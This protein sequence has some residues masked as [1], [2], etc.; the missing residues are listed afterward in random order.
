MKRI[1]ILF[2]FLVV[3][4]SYN[5]QGDFCN[6]AATIVPTFTNCSWVAGTSNNASQTLTGCSGN[7]DDDVWYTFVANSTSM[8]I[9]VDPTTGY[10]P[11]IQVFNGAGCSGTS[12]GC[13]DVNGLN[14][15]ESITLNSLTNGNTYTFRVYHYGVGSGTSNFSVCVTGIAPATNNTACNA[16]ALP[17]VSPSCNFQ[18]YTNAGSAGSNIAAPNG[19]GGSSP[20]QGGY[21]GG[22]VWFSVVVPA[23]GELD[24]HTQSIGFGDGAMALYSGSCF[25]PTLVTCD[26]D[27]GIG[28][29]PYIYRTNLTP[30]ATMYIRVWEYGNNNNGKFGICVSTPDNDNC[31]NAQWICD[32]NGY[33]GVTSSAYTIDLPG[34]MTGTGQNGV[35]NS[36]PSAPFG[37]NYTGSSPSSPIQIDNNSWLAFTANATS[38]Q[39][40]V[41]VNS[42]QN[43]NGLQMQIFQGTN[44]TNFVAVS[45]MLETTNSQ[46][47]TA[48]GLTPGQTYY[49]MVDGFAG[50]ICSYTISATSGIQV[51]QAIPQDYY[52]CAGSSTSITA[53]VSGSTSG[54]TY[55]WSSTPSGSYPNTQT[56]NVTP[57]SNTLYLVSVSGQS[58]C[59]G[60]ST[61]ATAYITVDSNPTANITT[62]PTPA[63]INS[64][65]SVNGNPSGGSGIYI[66][67]SWTG[68]G[69][70]YLS[71]TTSSSPTFNTATA[72]SYTLNYQVTDL[73]GCIGT[74][75]TTINVQQAPSADFTIAATSI[76]SGDNPITLVPNTAGGTFTATPS[77]PNPINGNS[78]DPSIAGAGTSS[79]TYQI[80]GTGNS[81]PASTTKP[82]TVT[83]TPDA[84][85]TSPTSFCTSDAPH[86]LTANSNGGTWTGPA[87]SNGVFSPSVA[88]AGTFTINYNVNTGGCSNSTSTL[89][90][91]SSTLDPTI[92]TTGPYCSADGTVDL[93]AIDEGVWSGPGIVNATTG[94]FDPSLLGNGTYTITNSIGGSCGS[95]AT[96]Q[97]TISNGACDND[98]D[99]IL[100][101]D[102]P[103]DD[104][105]GI[106]DVVED[107]NLD[108]DND[109][110]TNPTDTDGDGIPDYFDLDS[111]DDGIV[112]VIEAGGQ[113]PDGDGIIGTGPITDVDQDGLDDSVDPSQG[114]TPLPTPDSDNDGIVD[115]L[116]LDSDND[117]IVDNIEGQT[118]A[119]YTPPTGLDS[120]GDG[121]DN[122]YDADNNG[123]PV[124]PANTDLTDLPDYLDNDSDNDGDSDS[125]EGYD[126]DNDGTANITPSGNDSDSD[127]IDDAYDADGTSSN[128]NGGPSNGGQTPNNPFAN[129]DEPTTAELDWREPQ[130]NDNDGIS[131]NEDP[132]DDND[133]ILDVDE[134]IDGDGDPL[135][136]DTDGDGI[137]N[138]FD[139][140]S[141]NDGIVDVI[142]GGGEDP[143]GDGIIGD[144]PFIDN[145]NDGLSDIVDPSEGGTPLPNPDT[146]GDG[147]ADAVDYDSDNDGIVD[148]IEGQ[149]TEDYTAPSG[150]DTDGDGIDDVYDND[151][152]GTPVVPTDTDLDNA[153]DYLDID[154]D[155]DLEVDIIEGWDTNNDGIPDTEPTGNDS[156]ND[157]IDDAFDVDGTSSTDNGGAT[158]GGST[159]Q[160]FPNLDD[161]E[162]AELDWRELEIIVPNIFTPNGDGINDLFIVSGNFTELKGTIVNRWG[163]VIF[164]WNGINNSW[165]GRTKSSAEASEGTYF[166][167]FEA[168]DNEGAS[169]T[170]KG[171][172]VLER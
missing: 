68:S 104:N 153:P 170:F 82:I 22:D 113:D 73:W 130:D 44:C 146:D 109:P 63:C 11:V 26:D 50:D 6:N 41:N 16:F 27:A 96:E 79:I 157:G 1:S 128:N 84:T 8:T 19:C 28:S 159:P 155:N 102:D 25:A 75:S 111:D 138:V 51:V 12:L 2:S 129:A 90:T 106:L 88:G 166:Y 172:F 65:I 89:I 140:D 13:R 136:D 29:M 168:I 158:N 98:N 114:G 93:S 34:N 57:T 87:V 141:D 15:N 30:G 66:F 78:F 80:P 144:G 47:I 37:Q 18:T 69:A 52:I 71:S 58:N 120:D 148:N 60:V 83:A 36:N 56:I 81:C 142:E 165:D 95:A 116:D 14:G 54:L 137:P 77:T 152:G 76:C 169:T 38:A 151:N 97:I 9:K 134:D 74:N 42:C 124:I 45:N 132:D 123:T 24:I 20:F 67:H 149:T 121:I 110:F 43:N 162:S 33:G 117:G 118:T 139:L 85:I 105:D 99:G 64:P 49:I 4:I 21:L 48:S 126:P 103:D 163:N 3:A 62:S 46:T 131:D 115:F 40:Y 125:L 147:L 154:S 92:T 91:V 7:A 70:Q 135:N 39:L 122:A 23:S 53:N 171:S 161:T 17:A 160:S 112:D 55:T 143:D 10:D 156:D 31:S 150:N 72:G 119:G 133:G 107:E 100:N 164:N 59:G 127:G 32:L 94:E 167:I 145:D 101:D 108:N 5:A 35:P 86:T 61:T